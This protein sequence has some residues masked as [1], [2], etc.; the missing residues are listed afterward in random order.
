MEEKG[1][2]GSYAPVVNARV[3]NLSKS[4]FATTAEARSVIEKAVAKISDAQLRNV[5]RIQIL[6]MA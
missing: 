5:R 6:L 4:G 1:S 3:I 2:K